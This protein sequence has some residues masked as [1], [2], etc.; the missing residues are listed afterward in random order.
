M[1]KILLCCGGGFSSS[2]LSSKVGKEILE[3]KMQEDYYIEFSP[4]SLANKKM[5]EFD[6]VVCCPHLKF[7]V[8]S[9]VGTSNP[10][11]PI[12]I[13]PPKMYGQMNVK[14]LTLD[15]IDVIELYNKNK[16]N[17]VTFPGEE[18]VYRVTRNV[19]YRNAKI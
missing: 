15:V 3:N 7:D 17:P 12:Y 2:A 14:E 11:K 16:V 4:F 8:K 9:M 13:L 10:D 5:S 19:A 1:I 6:V 18:N